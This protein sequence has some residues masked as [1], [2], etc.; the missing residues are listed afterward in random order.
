[1]EGI[2]AARALIANRVSRASHFDV[3]LASPADDEE[4]RRLLREHPLPG[5]ACLTFE[6]EPDSAIAAAIE[7]D[8]HQTIVARERNGGRIAGI[9]G[10]S[11]RDVFVNGR[12][13]RLGYLGQLRTHVGSHR[14]GTLLDGGF[15]FCRALHDRGTVPAYLTAIV[16]DN[17]AARRLLG[18][19]RSPA[20]PRFV[21]AGRLVTLAIPRPR[22]RRRQR[23]PGIEIR[24]GSIELLQDIA[25]CLERSGRRHQFA[26]RWT[27]DDLLSDRRTPGLEARDFLVAIG[28]GRVIGCAAMWDQRAFKQVI[29]RSYSLRLARWRHVANLAAPWVGLPALPAVGRALQF[30]YLSHVA[31][32]DDRCDVT[33]ALVAD[34]LRRLPAGVDSIVTA[35]AEN[36]PMLPAA[37]SVGRHRTYRSVLYLACWPDGRHFVE[38]L[39]ARPPHPEVAIL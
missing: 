36:S 31:I 17:H 26:P 39:D 13:A 34:A 1:V 11:E 12:P 6:R 21:R 5:D 9:A 28:G 20:A 8:V 10:R 19:L 38:S 2:A 7:G 3:S 30:V 4:V 16:E 18:G 29:V 37:A 33:S 15:A 27:V 35:F 14:V 25:A 23:T 22:L 32:D 24:Q